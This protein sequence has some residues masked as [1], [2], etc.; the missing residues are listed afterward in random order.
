VFG[1]A[2]I[3]LAFIDL[4]TGYLPD[5]ITWPLIALGR[6]VYYAY[7]FASFCDAVIGAVA[8]FVSFW[9]IGTAFEKLRK[10]EGLGQGDK[11]LL[12]AIGAW[13]GWAML[14]LVIFTGAVVTLAA[15][16]IQGLGGKKTDLNL[17][18]PFGPGLCAAGFAAVL[19]LRTVNAP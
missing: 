5:A 4:E 18:A 16:F 19:V 12:A 1:W 15:I 10:K 8:G 11:K 2:R 7:I 3:A 14:P 6:G 9:F 17:P 13:C